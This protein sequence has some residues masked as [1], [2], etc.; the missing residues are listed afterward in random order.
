MTKIALINGRI[1]DGTGHPPV[2]SG[3]VVIGDGLLERVGS[4]TAVTVPK[5]CQVIDIQGKTVLPALIDGHMH[6]G[7]EPG[8]LDHMGHVRTNLQAVGKLQE[9]LRWGTGTVAHAA[10][11]PESMILRDVIRSGQVR[12]CSDLLIGAVVTATCGHVRGRSADGPW[13]IRK[14]VREMIA[15]GTDFIKTAASGGF[16]WEHEKLTHEDYTLE[17]L[18][19]LVAQ[20]HSRD[21]RVHVHAHAQPGL[22]NAIE[23]G[24]DVILH[25]ALIDE[26]ALEGMA[27]K[28]LW[29]MPTLYITSEK[30]REGKRWPAY[31]T[32]RMKAAHPIHCAGVAK[33]H[34]MGIKIVTGT[35]GGPGSIMNELCLF[36]DCGLS[37][38][39]ALVASTRSTADVLGILSRT[40]TLEAGKTADLLVVNGD[41]IQD[42]AILTSKDSIFLVI[43][44]GII[45]MTGGFDPNETG[46]TG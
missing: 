35:D 31:M 42:I 33:A 12:G 4:T 44:D 5:G 25:G 46:K 1:I 29:Y 32:E 6:V 30:A 2:N 23:A 41:P 34:T 9:C 19:V 45:Q 28:G 37:P 36:V 26:A 17:E 14:A 13:E 27:A 39:D 43:K 20:A 10:G 8:R 40:G 38:M 22:A 11:S 21:K 18:R 24:C 15:A 3:T 7:V 16:Q